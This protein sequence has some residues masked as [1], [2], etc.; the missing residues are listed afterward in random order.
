MKRRLIIV[1]YTYA[2]KPAWE[3]VFDHA[4]QVYAV[5]LN[6]NSGPGKRQ[7]PQYLKLAMKLVSLGIKVLGYVSTQYA[8]RDIDVVKAEAVRW[9]DWYEVAGIFFD[10][11]ASSKGKLPFYKRLRGTIGDALMVLNPGTVVDGEY[12]ELADIVC[13]AETSQASYAEKSFEPSKG[14]RYH[15]VY[16]VTD[17]KRALDQVN[18]NHADF[19]Y[20]AT[21]PGPNPQFSVETTIWG[22]PGMGG[23]G[24][25][26]LMGVSDDEL[27]AEV[28]RRMKR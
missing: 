23:M 26:G 25:M 27:L 4:D 9:L 24:G 12:Y 10:E 8:I 22:A 7:D 14:K 18:A 1:G 15:I 17:G 28:R 2:D 19:Y 6:V 11:A 3:A 20:L 16:G 13:D 5:I 21:V